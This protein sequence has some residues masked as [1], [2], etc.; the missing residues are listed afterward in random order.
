MAVSPN[1]S[2]VLYSWQTGFTR[3]GMAHCRVGAEETLLS[4]DQTELR[5]VALTGGRSMGVCSGGRRPCVL[6]WKSQSIFGPQKA[7]GRRYIVCSLAK[8]LSVHLLCSN[9][10]KQ[11]QPK[12]KPRKKLWD[13][14]ARGEAIKVSVVKVLK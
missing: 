5:S 4:M 8:R 1:I 10:L 9:K 6:V 13:G 3:P 14:E 12:T 7:P 11:N 2:K